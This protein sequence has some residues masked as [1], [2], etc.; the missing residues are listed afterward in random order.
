L[1]IQKFAVADITLQG[2]LRSSIQRV[3]W[4]DM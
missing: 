1:A 3:T 2:H 4:V